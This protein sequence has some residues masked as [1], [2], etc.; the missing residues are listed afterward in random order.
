MR[1]DANVT[2]SDIAV[3]AG[4][5]VIVGVLN[6]GDPATAPQY[7]RFYKVIFTKDET[8]TAIDNTEAEVKA[9]KV[10]R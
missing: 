7:L 5:V 6:E 1:S 3:A 8:P 10:T 4:E 9:I 2:T